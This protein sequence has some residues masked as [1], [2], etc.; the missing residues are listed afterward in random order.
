MRVFTSK[1]TG[2]YIGVLALLLSLYMLAACGKQEEVTDTG[3]TDK[4]EESAVP[5]EIVDLLAVN[6]TV[7]GQGTDWE[8]LRMQDEWE[9]V[10]CVSGLVNPTNAEYFHFQNDMAVL[11]G[12]LYLLL[13]MEDLGD[14][15]RASRYE[16][17]KINLSSM[18]TETIWASIADA[19]FAD[20]FGDLYVSRLQESHPDSPAW[21]NFMDTDG[22]NLY[23]FLQA[24]RFGEEEPSHYRIGMVRFSMC[25]ISRSLTAKHPEARGNRSSRN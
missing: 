3:A 19:D 8:N 23:F 16:L 4:Q 17:K 5:Q 25:L 12:D 20:V 13:Y 21:I 18:G 2:K 7:P 14:A 9:V 11:G 24:G 1:K 15:H 22:E 10:Q 6:W